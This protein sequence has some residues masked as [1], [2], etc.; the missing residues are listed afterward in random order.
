MP[1][2]RA[3]VGDLVQAPATDRVSAESAVDTA[4]A[5]TRVLVAA[6]CGGLVALPFLAVRYPPITD[7]PQHVAQIR[8]FLAALGGSDSG[9]AIQWFTPYST[10]YALLGAAW[11]LSSPANAGRLAVLVLG[12]LSTLAVH[13]LAA[14]RRRPIAAAVMASV[15]FFNNVI[16]WGFLSFAVGWLAFVVWFLVTTRAPV[17]GDTW[18]DLAA[19]FAAALLLYASHV[20]W[21]G[22][23]V[24]W[25][26]GYALLHRWPL[27]ALCRRLAAV[28]PVA[29]AAALWYPHLAALGFVSPTVWATPIPERLA[30]SWIVG[31][32]L[33]GT[34]GPAEYVAVA[35]IALWA[36]AGV[37]QH[38]TTLRTELDRDLLATGV[39]LAGLAFSL[40]DQYTNTIVFAERWLPFAAIL[41]LLAVPA[42]R[43]LAALHRP[44]A[45]AFVAAFSLA[46]TLIWMRFERDELSGLDAALAA[47]PDAPRVIGLDLVGDSDIIK[48]RPFIQTFAYAQ[49]LHGGSLNMSF[50]GHAPSL[51]VFRER[52]D[53]P[54]TPSLEWFADRVRLSDFAY[55]DYALINGRPD[56]HAQ[57]RRFHLT[58]VTASG[59]WRLYKVVKGEA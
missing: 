33:G 41:L 53:A 42:P 23:G 51:V 30:P 35:L 17:E 16:Y 24:V 3:A 38:R 50:A 12:V 1:T 52:A 56:I 2:V 4:G 14:R 7:L 46:T 11:S 15:L 5:R 28:A 48:G 25:L 18:R 26:V 32:V 59:R 47:L 55:F 58:P 9:Y 29:L 31:A 54:W 27:R 34:Y 10:A 40:P 22:F 6:L 19:Q 8:L 13:G 45:I 43:F 37:W 57:T 39:L 20:L 21:F 44:L 36:I 49:V